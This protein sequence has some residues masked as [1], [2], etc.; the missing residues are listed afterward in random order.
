MDINQVKLTKVLSVLPNN[1]MLFGSLILVVDLCYL[2]APCP[3]V[4]MEI[5]AL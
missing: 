5:V 3:Y 1:G 4:S 2:L